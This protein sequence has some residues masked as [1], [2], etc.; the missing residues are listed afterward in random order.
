MTILLERGRGEALRVKFRLR[1]WDCE[2]L[3]E[4]VARRSRGESVRRGVGVRERE[5]ALA[6]RGVRDRERPRERDRSYEG[7]RAD[8]ANVWTF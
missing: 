2:R 7:A 6:E 5:W 1:E 4:C 3:A 8:I